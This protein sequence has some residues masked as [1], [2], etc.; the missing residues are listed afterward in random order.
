MK[1]TVSIEGIHKGATLQLETAKEYD[2]LWS[3]LNLIL[4]EAEREVIRLKTEDNPYESVEV[5]EKVT[6]YWENRRNQIKNI[7]N[8][9]D[10]NLILKAHE[11]GYLTNEF[12]KIHFGDE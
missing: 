11:E 7:M 12:E 5:L 4:R 9:L 10:V 2:L 1:S 8:E 6:N 3:G